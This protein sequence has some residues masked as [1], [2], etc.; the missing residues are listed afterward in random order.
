MTTINTALSGLAA[1]GKRLETAANN[2]ANQNS[3]RTRDADGNSTNVPFQ[4]QEVVQ[5]SLT[6]GGVKTEVRPTGDQPLRVFDPGNPDA[7]ENG[8]VSTPNV[9]LEEQIVQTKLATY[10]YKANL[11]TIAAQDKLFE[12]LLDIIS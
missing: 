9:S 12:N 10:D 7:D 6:G 2:I 4:P 1:A 5:T 8:F 3:T 11:K